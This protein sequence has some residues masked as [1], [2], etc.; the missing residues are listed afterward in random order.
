MILK[1]D[2]MI[3]LERRQEFMGRQGY[4][5]CTIPACNCNS[6]HGGHAGQRLDEVREAMEDAGMDMNGKTILEGVKELLG[7]RRNPLEF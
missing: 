2:P 6:W 3:E 7:I 1:E 5:P 4:R